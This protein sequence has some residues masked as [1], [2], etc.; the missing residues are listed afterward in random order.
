MGRLRR[1]VFDALVLNDVPVRMQDAVVCAVEVAPRYALPLNVLLA[2]IE[3]EGGKPNSYSVN[4]DGSFD[5]GTMQINS[6]HL[7]GLAQYGITASHLMSSGCYPVELGAW[8]IARHLQGCSTEYWS[9]VARYH[10]KTPT[11]NSIY[12]AKVIRSADKWGAWIKRVFP[13]YRQDDTVGA[14]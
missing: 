4:T 1:I 3:V 8:M 12:R 14:R 5:Y 11:K 2:V 9:C 7:S 10:S 13:V 6:V